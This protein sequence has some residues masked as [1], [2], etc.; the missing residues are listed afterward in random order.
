MSEGFT[1]ETITSFDPPGFP[2]QDDKLTDQQKQEWS[3]TISSWM[4]EEINAGYTDE[5][6]VFHP[7]QAATKKGAVFNRTPLAQFFNGR[8]TPFNVSQKPT[9]ISWSGFPRL[10]EIKWPKKHEQWEHADANRDLHDEYLEWTVKK[11]D[12]GRITSVTFTCEGPEY[13]EFLAKHDKDKLLS[14]YQACNPEYADRMKV[15]DFFDSDGNYNP[16]NQW[17]GIKNLKDPKNPREGFVTTNPGCIMHL[18]QVNNTLGAEVDIAAQATVIRKDEDGNDITDKTKLCN[19][20]SYGQAQRHSDPQIG[21]MIN[22]L[23]RAG[24]KVS[25]AN[26]VGIYMNTF[27][28]NSFKLDDGSGDLKPVPS[29]TFTWVR[30]NINKHMG[31]RL[32]IEVPKGV[33]GT[34]DKEGQQLTVHDIV[35][36]HGKHI[37][38]GGQFAE[39]IRMCVNGV[40]ISGGEP[41]PAEPC[42]CG[43]K[44]PDDGR[45]RVAMMATASVKEKGV[46]GRLPLIKTRY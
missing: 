31:L 12:K 7:L 38:Y 16:F 21:I 8:L 10:V 36:K 43:S 3:D 40:T 42:P 17:N 26:P 34:E 24:N 41:A 30:G 20:S 19:C 45:S 22:G 23:A 35:D 18:A 25:I 1:A 28:S 44:A 11:N 37:K 5:D 46:Q 29:G 33:M 14:L 9:P 2:I 27:D 13:W 32:H 6:N 39:E 15:G 4:N